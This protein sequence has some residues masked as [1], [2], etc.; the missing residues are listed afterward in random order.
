MKPTYVKSFIIFQKI[1]LKCNGWNGFTACLKV[2]SGIT[3]PNIIVK[4]IDTFIA[5]LRIEYLS[6]QLWLLT[7]EQFK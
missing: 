6:K 1:V 4:S 3:R 7:T 2:I 5:F